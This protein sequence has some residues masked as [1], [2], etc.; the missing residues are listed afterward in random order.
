MAEKGEREKMHQTHPQRTTTYDIQNTT[1]EIRTIMQNK[2]NFQKARMN[3]T[4]VKTMNYEQITMNN[5]NKN[6]PNQ[7]Q[8]QRQA[9][10]INHQ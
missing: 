5:A 4:S 2:P 9:E 8:F 3:A 6:K 10:G 1:Y 7:T